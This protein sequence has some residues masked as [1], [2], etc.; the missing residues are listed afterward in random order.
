MVANEPDGTVEKPIEISKDR[1]VSVPL[2]IVIGVI[3]TV[4]AATRWVDSKLMVI[5]SVPSLATAVT[6]LTAEVSRLRSTVDQLA[7]N[8]ERL[9]EVVKRETRTSLPSTQPT[10]RRPPTVQAGGRG[11]DV[12]SQV[13]PE[14]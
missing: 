10:S 4:I 12:R 13:R 8:T 7:S 11:E 9:T 14:M 6:N 2:A 3:I 5:D 1:K